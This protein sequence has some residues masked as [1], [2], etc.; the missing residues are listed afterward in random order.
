M[1]PHLRMIVTEP[2]EH[3]AVN[4]LVLNE[5]F[6]LIAF[7]YSDNPNALVTMREM[8]ALYNRSHGHEP[9]HGE[10]GHAC[11]DPLAVFCPNEP[12][13]VVDRG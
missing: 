6:G 4:G 7:V 10:S 11:H 2:K 1:K 3:F 12:A 5:N 8:I 13:Q 9:A